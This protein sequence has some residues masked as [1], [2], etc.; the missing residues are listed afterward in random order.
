MQLNIFRLDQSETL[1]YHWQPSFNREVAKVLPLWAP[2]VIP[3]RNSV[4][5]LK[6]KQARYLWRVITGI[7]L[8]KRGHTFKGSYHTWLWHY[9]HLSTQS[10][11]ENKRVNKYLKRKGYDTNKGIE[12]KCTR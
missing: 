2:Q 4:L 7:K 1:G 3:N 10:I 6:E 8:T 5:F 12:P 9:G 11:N